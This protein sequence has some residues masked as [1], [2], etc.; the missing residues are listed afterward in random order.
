MLSLRWSNNNVIHGSQRRHFFHKTKVFR[1]EK[2]ELC[3]CF[4][5]R[6]HIPKH[7]AQ[8]EAPATTLAKIAFPQIYCNVKE[9]M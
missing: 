4:E 2:T 6:Q 1:L 3:R 9:T 8:S 7:E 5:F